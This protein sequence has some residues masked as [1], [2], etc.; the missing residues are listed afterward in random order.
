MFS[1]LPAQA[2]YRVFELKLTNSTTGQLRSVITTLDHLQYSTY[3]PVKKDET[4]EIAD[5]WMCWMRSDPSQDP[6]QRFC[7]SPRAPA[8][9]TPPAP[10]Q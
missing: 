5:T 4:I 10:P 1:A 7:R 2:E 6:A 8:A 3:Y 9:V